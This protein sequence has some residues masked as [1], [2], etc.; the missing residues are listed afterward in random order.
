MSFGPKNLTRRTPDNFLKKGDRTRKNRFLIEKNPSL[1]DIYTKKQNIV[2][3]VNPFYENVNPNVNQNVNPILDFIYK[4]KNIENNENINPLFIK[5]NENKITEQKQIPD[6]KQ[7]PE[8]NPSFEDI[9]PEY[10]IKNDGDV[11]PK[12]NG[13]INPLF[14]NPNVSKVIEENIS[15]GDIYTDYDIKNNVNPLHNIKSNGGKKRKTRQ[16]K[17]LR[18][19]KTKRRKQ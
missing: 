4:E 15:F 16:N 1:N 17:R 11:N 2:I 14:V 5:Q 18:K 9:Y 10:D 7:I 19:K 6:Q 12:K 3:G 13:D 8:Q